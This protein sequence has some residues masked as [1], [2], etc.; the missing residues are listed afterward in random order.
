MSNKIIVYNIVRYCII[1][2]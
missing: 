2:R 1:K